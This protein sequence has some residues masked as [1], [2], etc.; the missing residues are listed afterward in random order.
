MHLQNRT[1]YDLVNQV[2]SDKDRSKQGAPVLFTNLIANSN[3]HVL[4]VMAVFNVNDSLP[5]PSFQKS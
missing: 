5:A 3:F 1:D 4:I 2:I